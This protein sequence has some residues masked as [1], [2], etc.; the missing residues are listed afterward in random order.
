MQPRLRHL[1]AILIL[2]ATA[3]FGASRREVVVSIPDRALAV[4][5]EGTVLKVYPAAVGRAGSP[6]P[7]GRFTIINR[8]KDPGWYGR[9]HVIAPGPDNPLG[10][11]WLGL[12]RKHYG[13][14]GT[15][16]PHSIGAAASSGCIRM[17][18]ADVEELYELVNVG[19]PVEF[20]DQPLDQVVN[21]R[22]TNEESAPADHLTD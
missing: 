14:H 20:S 19:D 10:T 2:T 11:R 18:Q 12:S 1:I 4:I 17:Y 6:T 15:N 21:A 22:L 5:E 16:D 9:N 13:I 7:V 3:A 8:I